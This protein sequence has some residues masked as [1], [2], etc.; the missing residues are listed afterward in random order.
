MQPM[1]TGAASPEP[2]ERIA[3]HFEDGIYGFEDVKDFVLVERDS[4]RVIWSLRAA[5]GGFP[6]LIVV[7]PFVVMQGY[8]PQLTGQERQAL[9][10]PADDELCFLAVAVI[11]ENLADS[12]VNLK[13][14]IVINMPT[15]QAR[16]II[17]ENSDYP[18]RYR[19]FGN[20]PKRR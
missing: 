11:R 17:M 9:G 2:E 16:Q 18:V 5:E 1:A 15:R 7:D 14:P 8:R 3:I 6:T 12:V 19:L 4:S 10:N 13:S 20:A